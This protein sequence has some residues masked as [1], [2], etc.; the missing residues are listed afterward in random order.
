MLMIIQHQTLIC[1]YRYVMKKYV[2]ITSFTVSET[3]LILPLIPK[4][5]LS[6][7]IF[8]SSLTGQ[9]PW[10][11]RDSCFLRWYSPS[12]QAVLVL[13]PPKFTLHNPLRLIFKLI[14]KVL[15]ILV[16]CSKLTVVPIACFVNMQVCF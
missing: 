12:W 6:F 15:I 1:I 8:I 3:N 13:F 14:F 11:I 16:L 2:E 9:K 5:L 7:F 10:V 4:Q